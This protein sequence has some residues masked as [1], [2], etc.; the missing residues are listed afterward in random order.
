MDDS[1]E[2]P[3]DHRMQPWTAGQQGISPHDL[4]RN[5]GPNGDSNG[6]KGLVETVLARLRPVICYYP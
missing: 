2:S 1:E 5:A 6:A 3:P 4:Q